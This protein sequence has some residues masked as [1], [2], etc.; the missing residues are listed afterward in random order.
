MWEVEDETLTVN[1]VT[2]DIWNYFCSQ[3]S[4]PAG[5]GPQAPGGGREESQQVTL[6]AKVWGHQ[7]EHASITRWGHTGAVAL[8]WRVKL[9]RD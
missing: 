2:V 7:G 4:D 6:K 5:G 8:L 1:F 9:P 3:P